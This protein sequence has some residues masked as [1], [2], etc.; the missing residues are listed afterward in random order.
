MQRR[1][2]A[3]A[4]V[5]AAREKSLQS[6]L[7]VYVNHLRKQGKNAAGDAAGVFRRHII[8]A[9][10][11]LAQQPAASIDADTIAQILRRLMERGKSRT[12]GKLRSYLA[13]AYNLALRA[14]TDPA[15]PAD[16]MGFRLTA[17]PVAATKA[18]TGVR[19]RDRVLDAEELKH[20]L[21]AIEARRGPVH[22]A[23]ILLLLLGGQRPAQLL[24]ARVADVDL[25]AATLILRD[26][27]GKR[28]APRIHELPLSDSAATI[29]RRRLLAAQALQSE[30][31]FTSDGR[32]AL[33]P[34][35]L[36]AATKSISDALL[37]E[38]KVR[39]AFQ[40]RDLRR[41]CE[42]MLAALGISREVRAQ[43]LSHGLS[44]VQQQ[45]YDRHDYRR[46]KHAALMAWERRLGEIQRGEC[47]PS[48]VTALPARRG[49]HPAW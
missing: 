25:T 1:R 39:S 24:R 22:D 10:P 13:S 42:T 45:H 35:T 18:H 37:A 31:L 2:E 15:A 21:D 49:Q 44:G 47:Q 41:T 43:L 48:N 40:L 34:E 32:V 19:A 23:L 16:A 6:L 5:E 3:L 11:Q 27:K 4:A 14:S 36:S 7:E 46:E 33:R 9:Y 26:P 12:A 20:V 38:R 29:V 17:N 30:W 28:P 8:Q